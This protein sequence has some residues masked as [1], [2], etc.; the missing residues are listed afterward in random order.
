MS[1][2]IE[3]GRIV[4]LGQ[5]PNRI[6]ILISISAVDFSSAWESRVETVLGDQPVALLG[7]DRFAQEQGSFR[8]SEGQG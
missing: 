5:P 2:L 6:D 4:S 3:Q 8:P 1:D 7:L